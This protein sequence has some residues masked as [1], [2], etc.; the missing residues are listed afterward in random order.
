MIAAVARPAAHQK[1]WRLCRYV[2]RVQDSGDISVLPVTV[3]ASTP[4]LLDDMLEQ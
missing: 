1:L 3:R 2:V 4:G